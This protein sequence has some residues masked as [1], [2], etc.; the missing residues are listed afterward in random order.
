MI[1]G[2]T[3]TPSGSFSRYGTPGPHSSR[4]KPRSWIFPGL[5]KQAADA[6]DHGNAQL[7]QLLESVWGTLEYAYFATEYE[8]H[9]AEARRITE[10]ILAAVNTE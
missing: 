2:W 8:E 7:L 9:P 6:L 10:P 3:S 4:A 1:V 5:Q